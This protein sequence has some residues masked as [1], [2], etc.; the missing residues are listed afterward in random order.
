MSDWIEYE[1]IPGFSQ[2]VKCPRCGKPVR[3]LRMG[4]ASHAAWHLKQDAE[5]ERLRAK[6]AARDP[7]QE[8]A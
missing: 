6:V 1:A 5:M 3:S 4:R 8:K 7:H 2:W